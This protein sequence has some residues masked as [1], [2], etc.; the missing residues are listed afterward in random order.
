M[1]LSC[2]SYFAPMARHQSPCHFRSTFRKSAQSRTQAGL[3]PATLGKSFVAR[4]DIQ[5]PPVIG[6]RVVHRAESAQCT[7]GEKEL[8]IFQT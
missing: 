6:E 1:F 3:R 7:G 8:L 4:I 2:L 5:T